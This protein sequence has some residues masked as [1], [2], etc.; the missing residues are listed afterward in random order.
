MAIFYKY[1]QGSYMLRLFYNPELDV[2]QALDCHTVKIKKNT[3]EIINHK[4]FT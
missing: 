4:S 1:L 2:C 3:S